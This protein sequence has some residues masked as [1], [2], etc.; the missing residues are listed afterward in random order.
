MAPLA[1]VNAAIGLVASVL[2]IL[3]FVIEVP[4]NG[5][6]AFGS[7]YELLAAAGCVISAVLVIKISA[8]LAPS[9]ASRTFPPLVFIALIIGAIAAV[10]VTINVFDALVWILV[11]AAVIFVEAAWMFWV[12]RQLVAEGA[13]RSWTGSLGRLIGL[14]LMIGLPLAGIGLTLQVLTI[15]QILLLG[16][17]VFLAGGVWLIWPLWWLLVGT[18][19][20]RLDGAA[21]NSRSSAGNSRSSSGGSRPSTGGTRSSTTGS[22]PTAGRTNATRSV[23]AATPTRGSGRRSA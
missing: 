6:Y 2:L 8:R 11:Q 16:V 23:S 22:R 12:N 10:L 1:L 15:P 18:Q 7:G 21:G 4:F 14:G 5:P 9:A 3:M 20:R 13:I 17:G 19:L